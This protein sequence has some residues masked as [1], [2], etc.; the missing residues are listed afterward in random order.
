MH[1][2]N[3]NLVCILLERTT[4]TL[5]VALAAIAVLRGLLTLPD[6]SQSDIQTYGRILQL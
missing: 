2:Y 4:A 6:S 3:R 1:E 5:R